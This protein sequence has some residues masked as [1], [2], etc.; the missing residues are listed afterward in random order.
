MWTFAVL[1]TTIPPPCPVGFYCL[2][3]NGTTECPVLHYRDTPGA[4]S[5]TDCP[6]CHAGY[7]CNY[8]GESWT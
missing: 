5:L 3:G 2:E 7:Y 4:A 6:P 8:T 1:G